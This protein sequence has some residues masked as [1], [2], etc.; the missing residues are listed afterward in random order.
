[1]K[2]ATSPALCELMQ[3]DALLIANTFIRAYLTPAV[4]MRYSLAG[5]LRRECVVIHG[6]ISIVVVPE[7]W[8]ERDG[9]LVS[10]VDTT[11]NTSTCKNL[12]KNGPRHKELLFP[13]DR[14]GVNGYV[15][16]ELYMVSIADYGRMLAMRT[17]DSAYSKDVIASAWR[18]KGYVGTDIG[19]VQ[20]KYAVQIR[21]GVWRPVEN[22]PVE[23]L[24]Y[25]DTEAAFF[26][27]L[28]IKYLS[29]N[30]RNKNEWTKKSRR[31]ADGKPAEKVKKSGGDG[32]GKVRRRKVQK[33]CEPSDGNHA[34]AE[35]GA[36]SDGDK[37]FAGGA[38]AS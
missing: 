30:N 28:G 8:G 27:W 15:K 26:E 10:S 14:F 23:A 9:N 1:M 34:L 19:L 6:H 35:G 38:K 24:T 20:E 4:V 33:V 7:W 21:K 17:G 11:V 16:L 12:I 2:K 25:F 22:I 31:V 32:K 18:R 29:P 13:A 3:P 5:E 36:G 37:T